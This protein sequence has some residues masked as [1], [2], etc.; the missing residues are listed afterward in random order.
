MNYHIYN[1]ETA[2]ARIFKKGHLQFDYIEPVAFEK[3]RD[4]E[5]FSVI[6]C[7][8]LKEIEKEETTDK[9][10]ISN[11]LTDHYFKLMPIN[12]MKHFSRRNLIGYIMIS[13]NTYAAVYK[14][15]IMVPL[16]LSLIF[17]AVFC[18]I[19]L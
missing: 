19:V 9:V 18:I 8:R 11:G 12:R 4:T 5:N 15:R 13:K 3:I 6:G 16:V 14:S 2:N 17:L 1:I 7:I 10:I